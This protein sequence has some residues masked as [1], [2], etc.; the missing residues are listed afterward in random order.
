MEA[1]AVGRQAEEQAVVEFLDALSVAPAALVIEGDP[2]IGKTTLW[3]EALDRAR[4][5]GFVVLAT[6]AARA[7]S[8]LAYAALADLLS[9]VDESIWADLPAPQQQSLDA[10]LL[11]SH[12][13]AGLSDAR[14]VAAAFAAVLDRLVARSEGF[15]LVAVD[16]L[17]WIDISS[18]NAVAFAA[19]RLPMGAGLLCTTRSSD[20]AARVQLARPDAVRRMRLQPLTI[21]ALHGVLK[22]QLGISVT[23]PML[24]RIHEL[25]GGNPFYGVELA[26][27]IDTTIGSGSVQLPSSLNDLVGSR[28]ARIGPDAKDVLLATASV[29]DPTIQ[30]LAR[31]TDNTAEHV[32]EALGEAETQA[33]VVID[34]NRV[35]FTHP[36]LAHGVYSQA[37]PPRRRAMHQKLAELVV[38]PELRARHLALSD[39]RSAKRRDARRRNGRA[40]LATG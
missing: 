30:L 15:V 11:R 21:E 17:Q 16:D 40:G 31:A 5:R 22:Q 39:A 14:A 27:D 12:E 19:R 13:N 23:R 6:R 10:A 4:E 7:E 26:R 25:A 33:V 1:R 28:I 9:D 20:V 24:L 35:S 18:A 32:L 37:S 3:L 38:E 2:G 36:L 29:P 34:G 8:V